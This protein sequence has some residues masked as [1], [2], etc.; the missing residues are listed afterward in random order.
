MKRI[1]PLLALLLLGAVA[2]FVDSPA[3]ATLWRNHLVVCAPLSRAD[4]LIVLGGEAV[5]R[6]SEAARLY[7]SGVAPLIFVTGIGDAGRN[8]Q[9]LLSAGVPPES[10]VLETKARTTHGNAKNLA[11]MLSAKGIRSAL[12]VTSPFH[13]RR[14]LATFRT[15]IPGV[16]FG[17]VPAMFPWWDEPRGRRELNRYALVEELKLLEYR[18][19]YGIR[20]S[21]GSVAGHP[22]PRT[23]AS[24]RA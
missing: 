3:F 20:P 16:E 6:P 15:L 1:L 18:L 4:V 14:A 21:M 8:R 12:I 2:F 19:L 17:I 23:A 7:H 24:P 13:T 22:L 11:P 5:G 10:I 9:A